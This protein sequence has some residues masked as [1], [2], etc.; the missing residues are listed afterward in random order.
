MANGCGAIGRAVA[1]NSRGLRFFESS[2]RPNLCVISTELEDENKV[3]E[4]RLD[5]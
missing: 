3:K 2:H 1:S 4:G 5:S